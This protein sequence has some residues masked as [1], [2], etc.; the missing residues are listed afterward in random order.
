MPP[1]PT[2][3]SGALT[4]PAPMTFVDQFQFLVTSP[5]VM[6]FSFW[7]HAPTPDGLANVA[8]PSLTM[9]AAL[10]EDMARMILTKLEEARDM[11]KQAAKPN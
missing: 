2:D 9:S 11:A 8:G 4:P 6:K 7:G 10:A 3:H 5:G 1:A